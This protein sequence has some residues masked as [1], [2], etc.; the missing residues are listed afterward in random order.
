MN[1]LNTQDTKSTKFLGVLCRLDFGRVCSKQILSPIANN[2]RNRNMV[3]RRQTRRRLG[4][5]IT[6]R[7]VHPVAVSQLLKSIDKVR[8]R[9]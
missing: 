8:D 1:T 9:R 4:G 3:P 6:P 2:F 5:R 7:V